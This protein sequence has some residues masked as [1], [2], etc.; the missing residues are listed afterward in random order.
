LLSAASRIEETLNE[1]KET[2]SKLTQIA[3]SMVNAEATQQ[4]TWKID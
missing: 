2:D 4:S 3:E 1:E